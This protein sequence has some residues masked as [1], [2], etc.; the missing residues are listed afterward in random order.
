MSNYRGHVAGAGLF[1]VL[2]LT[3]LSV[4]LTVDILP[5]DRE[6]F[7]GYAFPVM[8]VGLTVLF[9]IFPDVDINSRAQNMFYSIFFLIDVWLIWSGN[10]EEA[11]YL[12]L[13]A[14]L[15]V[16][17]KHRGWTHSKLAMVLV[18]LPILIFPAFDN[19]HDVWVGLPYYGAAVAGYFSHLFFD[20]LIIKW[21]KRKK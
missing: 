21:R 5:E 18:P 20:Q 10:F 2:Y 19:P 17:S 11:A 1:A 3:L 14:M 7:S 16:I 12:G 13:L 15:P 8:L 4:V 9:G 6:I